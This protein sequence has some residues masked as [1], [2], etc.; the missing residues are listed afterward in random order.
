MPT[1]A[2][3][4]VLTPGHPSVAQLRTLFDAS[5]DVICLLDASGTFTSVSAAA[6]RVWGYRPDELVG[7]RSL[8]F[9]HPDDVPATEAAVDA[10]LAGHPTNMF[11]NR[12]RCANGHYI[13]VMWSA[14][15]DAGSGT[16]FCI[17]RDASERVRLE[18]EADTFRTFVQRQQE[19]LIQR[20][21]E[22]EEELRRSNERF[23]LA[24]RTDAIF[25]WDIVRNEVHWGEGIYNVFGYTGADFQLD[26]WAQ[27][28]HPEDRERIFGSLDATL[29]NPDAHQWEVEYRLA[30]PNG[31][32][33]HTCGIG[34]ILRSDEGAA[35]RM[36]GRLQDIS[37]RKHREEE[38]EKL[39]LITQQ[40]DDAIVVTDADKKTTWVNAAFTRLT[41]YTLEDMLG[42][43][44]AH[45]LEGPHLSAELLATVDAYYRD[46]KPF[47]LETLNY[48]KNGT[49]FWSIISVQPLLDAQGNVIEY[50]SIRKD[51]TERKLLEQQLEQQRQQMTSAVIAAQEKERSDMSQELHDNVNQ[52]LTTVKLYQEL[53]L[54]G[55]GHAD[56]L[57]RKSMALLQDSINEIRS[58]SKRLSAP[59]LGK[60]RLHESVREL[61]DAVAAT[62]KLRVSLDTSDI[63][64]Y[65]I[66]QDAH[67]A[68]YRIL[69]E[70]LTNVLKHAHAKQVHIAFRLTNTALTM[71]VRDDGIGF[72][73]AQHHAGTGLTNMRSRAD[74]L[75]GSIDVQ[76]APGGGCSITVCIPREGGKREEG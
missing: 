26:H 64:D 12:Y 28:V 57:A 69:Q 72:R 68:L 4:S 56:E 8:H 66:A 41:G 7:Q 34:Y 39:S 6:L 65:E 52:V 10:L 51:I 76:S 24:A 19:A 75:H 60:I 5:P 1:P 14:S 58:I 32:W 15:W 55:I 25:D 2:P 29:A 27:R 67:I 70:Q 45:V 22:T 30:R 73:P 21:Q 61:T 20:Q 23:R 33:C 35:L 47:T 44:P 50:F 63:L 49:P 36:V 74:G 9:V 54:S 11:E 13:P 62:N 18:A 17:A 53:L 31:T 37:E 48:R 42:R 40:T 71:E 46:K 16:F 3:T 38:L 59:S 43:R